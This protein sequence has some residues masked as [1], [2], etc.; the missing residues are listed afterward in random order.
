MALRTFKECERGPR[1]SLSVICHLLSVICYMS[2]SVELTVLRYGRPAFI[3][4]AAGLGVSGETK[5]ALLGPT[6]VVPDG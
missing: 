4:P 5:G 2:K 1:P 6:S 3:C